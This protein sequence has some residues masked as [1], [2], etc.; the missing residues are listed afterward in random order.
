MTAY[1]F[2]LLDARVSAREQV[3]TDAFM[4]GRHLT[5]DELRAL[6]A[7]HAAMVSELA[8]YAHAADE[9]ERREARARACR[10]R[11]AAWLLREQVGR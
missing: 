8:V 10:K 9:R 7:Y 4:L 6:M 2:G 1:P 11:A 3:T 5:G